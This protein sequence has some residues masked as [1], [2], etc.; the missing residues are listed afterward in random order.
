MLLKILEQDKKEKK[1]E[2]KR[3]REKE[4]GRKGGKPKQTGGRT[5]K[6][7]LLVSPRFGYNIVLLARTFKI[8]SSMTFFREGNLSLGE[9]EVFVSNHRAGE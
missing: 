6:T 8:S 9:V 2:R 1:K 4:E 7:P 3:E 5:D